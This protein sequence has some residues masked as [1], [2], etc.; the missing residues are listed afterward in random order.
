MDLHSSP[1]TNGFHNGSENAP[2]LKSGAFQ[3][4]QLIPQQLTPQ[5]PVVEPPRTTFPKNLNDHSWRSWL[6]LF[7][8]SAILGFF[9]MRLVT[10]FWVLFALW[11][12]LAELPAGWWG[13]LVWGGVLAGCWLMLLRQRRTDFTHFV[14]SVMPAL[15]ANL[16]K[17]NQKVAVYVTGEFNVQGKRRRFTWLPGFY[18]TFGTREHAL[19]GQ[20]NERQLLWIANWPEQEVG[21]WYMFIE[22]QSIQRIQVG[23]L[24]FAGTPRPAIA[25]DYQLSLPSKRE[26]DPPQLVAQKVYI[27]AEVAAE[28]PAILADLIFDA[29]RVAVV[30]ER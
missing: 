28:L 14:P 12:G 5:Q 15:A 8:R 18:R 27:V 26:E 7:S 1:S 17:S 21:L 30:K 29:P 11:W 25:I 20:V 23:E 16:L 24:H 10:V 4:Q 6:Y 19:I 22:P 13:A 3:S 2:P 9:S